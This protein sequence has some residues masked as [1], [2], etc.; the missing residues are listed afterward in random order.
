[1]FPRHTDV[2]AQVTKA[3]PVATALGR[4]SGKWSLGILLAAETGAV[5]F[6]E[7]ER[8]MTGISRRMLTLNLR[9]LERD[10][11]LLRTVHPTVPPKVD[12][13]LTA[14]GRD[15]L[16]PLRALSDWSERHQSALAEAQRTY[17]RKHGA[18]RTTGE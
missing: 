17:D 8:G 14:L 2:S 5:R 6:T 10:G 7:L 13:R 11:L 9:K 4:V 16:E 3:C 18:H 1:M 12:Y 15:L